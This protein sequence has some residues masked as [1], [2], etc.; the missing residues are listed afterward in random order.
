MKVDF[1]QLGATP[2]DSVVT[3]LATRLLGEDQQLLLVSSDVSQ[4]A[5][6]DRLLWSDGPTFL[7]HGIAGTT[8]DARQPVLLSTTPDAPNLARN[9]LIADGEWREAALSFDRAF[10]LFDET[11]LEPARLAWKLLS[12]RDGVERRYWA[13]E[14]RRWTQKA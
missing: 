12:G 13:Q 11:H 2:I 6:L 14:D 7:P 3:A 10:F 4:L 8:E 9:L 1:Y 5:R